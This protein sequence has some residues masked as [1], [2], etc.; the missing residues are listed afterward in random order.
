MPFTN[1]RVFIVRIVSVV[2]IAVASPVTHG[3]T[4]L[5]GSLI[6][7]TTEPVIA[8]YLGNSASFTNDLYLDSPANSLGRIFRNHLDAV[9]STFNL[10]VFPIGTELVFR[11]HVTNN[12]NNFF[13]GPASRNPDGQF[14]TRVTY[15]YQGIPNNTLVEFEDLFNG[16]FNYNDLSF[17]F[18]NVP[19]PA[20]LPLL[21]VSLSMLCRRRR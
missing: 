17:A 8:T 7:Q 6:V 14:H 21:A 10:G 3:Q 1:A 13:S 20:T 5:G 4:E 2:S 19:S 12:G 16:P 11:L 15:N 18:T 9:G